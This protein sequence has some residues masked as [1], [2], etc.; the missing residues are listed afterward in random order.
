MHGSS[1]LFL[2]ISPESEG[3]RACMHAKSHVYV[4]CHLS[5]Q[6]KLHINWMFD[7][8]Q[9]IKRWYLQPG[10]RGKSLKPQS[11]AHN[12]GLWRDAEA[13]E[14]SCLS[15]TWPLPESP[16]RSPL[17][18]WLWQEVQPAC[19]RVLISSVYVHAGW[20]GPGQRRGKYKNGIVAINHVKLKP[21]A[22]SAYLFCPQHS[23][24]SSSSLISSPSTMAG[25]RA[26][27]TPPGRPPRPAG[28]FCRYLCSSSSWSKAGAVQAQ[29]LSYIMHNH[30]NKKAS[31]HK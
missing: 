7:T 30:S 12:W 4:L 23:M 25:G 5:S 11:L 14:T 17:T 28:D 31:P 24:P 1:R 2:E 27:G 19:A 26:S 22:A 13:V 3:K 21:V 29:G 10:A 18:P 6:V 9:R 15:L 8:E 20:A 16:G